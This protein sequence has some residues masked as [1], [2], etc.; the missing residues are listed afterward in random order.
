[1]LIH[2][3]YKRSHGLSKVS[4]PSWL[5]FSFPLMY[6]TDVLE[7]PGILTPGILTELGYKDKR[8]QEAIDLVISKQ[9]GHGR[10]QLERT[11]NG[12]LQFNIGGKSKPNKWITLKA[13]LV[14][15]RYY[16]LTLSFPKAI[17][18]KL[19]EKKGRI[20][21]AKRKRKKIFYGR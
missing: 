5:K 19:L 11:F 21:E 13:L 14:L 15:E 6:Q 4:K 20:I 17:K 9:D 1:M 8:M 10:W 3:T 7:I 2:H 18:R 12:R 16:Q